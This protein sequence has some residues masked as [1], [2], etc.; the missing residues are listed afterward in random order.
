MTTWIFTFG[1]SHPLGDKVQPIRGNYE[2]ARAMMFKIYGVTW[3]SQYLLSELSGMNERRSKHGLP[4]LDLLDE[5]SADV[6][7]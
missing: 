5:V 2:S 4:P 3:C 1:I 6:E 7:M